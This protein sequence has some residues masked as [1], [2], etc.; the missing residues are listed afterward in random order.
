MRNR[1]TTRAQALNLALTWALPQ[2]LSILSSDSPEHLAA[3]MHGMSDGRWATLHRRAWRP[4]PES[5]P[6]DSWREEWVVD[7]HGYQAW[8]ACTHTCF[9][10]QVNQAQGYKP[11]GRVPGFSSRYFPTVTDTLGA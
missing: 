6:I 11:R 5:Q 10:S 4:P 2:F 3:V 9:F 1:L 7:M 8:R